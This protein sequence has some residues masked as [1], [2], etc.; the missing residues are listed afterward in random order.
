M[1]KSI[2]FLILSVTLISVLLLSCEELKDYFKDPETE[3]LTDVLKTSAV[4]GFSASA[5]M[6]VMEG[7]DVPY[8]KLK[9]R[10]SGFPCVSIMAIKIGKNAP[11][12]YWSEKSGEIIVAG[13]WADN[14]TA[15]LTMLLTDFD[16]HTSTFKLKNIYT[17]P[18]I[19]T[20]DGKLMAAFA[21]MDINFNPETDNLL[22]FNL[23]TGEINSEYA[24]IPTNVT[25]DLYVAVEQDAYVIEIEQNNT[26]D[27]LYDDTYYVS[28]GGQLV[29]INDNK[30]EVIQQAMVNVRF[31]QSCRENPVFGYGL[32]RKIGTEGDKFPE[33][34]TVVLEFGNHCDGTARVTLATGMYLGA[35]GKDIPLDFD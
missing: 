18:V 15:I 26:L 24:R 17:I 32:I 19:R 8:V 6:S 4:I 22:E 2:T 29:E 27:N 30:T 3:S 7:Y 14:S 35:N 23:E 21:S 12:P 28:G 31:N 1:K 9:T 33:L 25:D 20:F 16:I 5:A 34:G 10:C 13:L 11:F